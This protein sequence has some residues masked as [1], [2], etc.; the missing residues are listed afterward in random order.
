MITK[1]S[2]FCIGDVLNNKCI[3]Y[4]TDLMKRKISIENT[5]ILYRNI[6][7]LHLNPPN[8]Q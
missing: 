2:K 4:Y 7:D 6:I 1:I 3:C 5:R 8:Y